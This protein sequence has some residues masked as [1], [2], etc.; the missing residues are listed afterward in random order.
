MIHN[1]IWGETFG[2]SIAE[3]LF[4]DKP[5][6]S[7]TGGDGQAHVEMMK[8]HAIWYDNKEDLYRAL[9]D[10]NK[11]KYM[12]TGVFKKLVEAYSP[13]RVMEKFEKVFLNEI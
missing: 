11:A 3:F 8:D 13:D 1:G 9:S 10:F 6:L 7:W 5:I 2:C 4:F 12:N